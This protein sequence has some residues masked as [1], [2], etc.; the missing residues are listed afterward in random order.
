MAGPFC[1]QNIGRWR[2]RRGNAEFVAVPR[3]PWRWQRRRG[4]AECVADPKAEC[5]VDPKAEC[6]AV[7][8][9][10]GERR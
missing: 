3:S 9:E 2:R 5:V 4:N 6:V 8:E 1:N 10:E 7:A